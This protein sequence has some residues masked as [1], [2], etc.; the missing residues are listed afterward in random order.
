MSTIHW[1]GFFFKQKRYNYA[2]Y[3]NVIL[4]Q[5]EKG[6]IKAIYLIYNRTDETSNYSNILQYNVYYQGSRL[7]FEST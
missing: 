5:K 3:N 6:F 7:T 4:I 1:F 2:W